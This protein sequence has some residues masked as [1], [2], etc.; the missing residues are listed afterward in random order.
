MNYKNIIVNTI[1]TFILLLGFYLLTEKQKDKIAYIKLGRVY[2]GFKMK[3][4]LESKYQNVHAAR[5]AQLD[6]LEFEL[7]IIYQKL[8][9]TATPSKDLVE[10]Y[11]VKKEKY[12][13]KKQQVTEDNNQV[14]EQ[15]SGQIMKK[16]NEYVDN[17]GKDRGYTF[18]LG[19]D[20]NG[21]IMHAEDIKD[22]TEDVLAY[23]NKNYDGTSK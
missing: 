8:N 7:N 13:M 9:S 20:G 17:Y 12:F 4:D 3:K 1:I 23:I 21:T 5:K 2:E 19:A 22:V 16:I 6:S 14:V 11:E 15:Y 18:I 10:N